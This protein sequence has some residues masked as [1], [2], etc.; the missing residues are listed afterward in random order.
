MEDLEI[1]KILGFSLE[2]EKL[3]HIH[4]QLADEET[5]AI[6]SS[7]AINIEFNH[8]DAQKG[9][10][11]ETLAK[12]MGID[13][14]DVMTLGDNFNDASMLQMAGRGVAMGN[15]EPEIKAMCNY[16][17]KDNDA[18]GIEDENDEMMNEVKEGK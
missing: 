5:L 16:T 9:L 12:G 6:T 7:G 13:M 4:N 17:T 18:H 14:Q 15:A 10:A 2:K 1:Y 8:V 3:T 11:L